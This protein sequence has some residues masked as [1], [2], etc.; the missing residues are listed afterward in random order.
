[1][2]DRYENSSSRVKIDIEY[3]FVFSTEQCVKSLKVDLVY[4]FF[5]RF[6]IVK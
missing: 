6:V 1:M 5:E 3:I 2:K 4:K